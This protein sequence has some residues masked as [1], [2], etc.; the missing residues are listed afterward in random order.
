MI[1]SG[2]WDFFG[3]GCPFGE[4]PAGRVGSQRALRSALNHRAV[5]DRIGKRDADF[6]DVRSCS[7]QRQDEIDGS[8]QVRIPAVM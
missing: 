8:F 1:S 7:F 2:T 6:N 4:Y 3:L 5:R